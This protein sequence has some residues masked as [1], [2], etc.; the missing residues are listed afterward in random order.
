MTAIFRVA[1]AT[2]QGDRLLGGA[3]SAGDRVDFTRA[4]SVQ[5]LCAAILLM[6]TAGC[7]A[8]S[9]SGPAHNA[10]EHRARATLAFRNA[11][12]GYVLVDLNR[13]V[14]P[15]VDDPGAGSL[16]QTFGAGHGASPEIK[17][18]IGDIV[19]VTLFEDQAGGLFIPMDAGARPGNFVSLPN[20]TVDS[21]GY[22]TIPYAGQI[23]ALNRSTPSIQ[24]EIVARLKNRA[25]EPQAVVSVVTQTSNQATVVGDVTT[26]GKLSINPAGDRVL[27]VIAR[28]GGIKDPGY[29]T[30]VTLQRR[31]VKGTVYFLNLVQNPQEN[32]FVSPGDTIYVYQYQRAFVAYGAVGYAGV[33]GTAAS[34]QFKFQQEKLMLNDAVGKAGGLLDSRSDPAQ[35]FVYRLESRDALQKMGANVSA[36]DPSRPSVPT[37]YRVDFRDPSSF[38]LAQKFPM[39]DGDVLYVDNADATELAKFVSFVTA[40]PVGGA[41]VSSSIKTIRSP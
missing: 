14:L 25:I 1:Q 28:A 39:R 16:F 34:T 31:G 20:Q 30:F 17:V 13:N 32:I 5:K 35:V 10:I 6:S 23:R 4:K 38:F 18:G 21:R 2:R 36:F 26:P 27:D 7:A 40:L 22:I 12:V 24:E 33:N 37:I 11:G 8:L 3:R 41:Q 19:E 9:D 29:E 15:Y